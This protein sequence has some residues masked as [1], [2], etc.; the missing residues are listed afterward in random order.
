MCTASGLGTLSF[1][2]HP[3]SQRKSQDNCR[4]RIEEQTPL[5]ND[6][7]CKV[8]LQRAWIWT[9]VEN[10]HNFDNKSV[11]L[12][13]LAIVIDLLSCEK[14]THPSQTLSLLI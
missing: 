8:M 9:G 5:L 6:R 1:M 10:L 7:A 2:S 4:L 11:T 12:Y 14:C 3:R 13:S